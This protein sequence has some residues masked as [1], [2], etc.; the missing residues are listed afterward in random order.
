MHN[1]GLWRTDH[2]YSIIPVQVWARNKSHLFA[3]CLQPLDL[4]F[5]PRGQKEVI[6]EIKPVRNT[7]TAMDIET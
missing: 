4:R 6:C 3:L 7:F 5:K 1:L 2:Q